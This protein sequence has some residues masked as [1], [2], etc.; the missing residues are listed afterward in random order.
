MQNSRYLR[1][2]TSWMNMPARAYD[3]CD[4]LAVVL[5]HVIISYLNK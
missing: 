4:S 1:L 2:L 3:L 5:L